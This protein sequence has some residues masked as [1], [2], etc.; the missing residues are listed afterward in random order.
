MKAQDLAKSLCYVLGQGTLL[1]QCHSSNSRLG[2]HF[3]SRILITGSVESS[4]SSSSCGWLLFQN[5]S[6][7]LSNSFFVISTSCEQIP[8]NYRLQWKLFLV[9]LSK[10][11]YTQRAFLHQRVPKNCHKNLAKSWG[12]GGGCVMV[13]LQCTS[14]PYKGWSNTPS[15]L[16]QCQYLS[17]CS[18]TP[19]LI[20]H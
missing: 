11:L 10:A 13:N 3:G 9:F 2:N 5:D 12:K 7:F 1:S 14:I 6:I 19:P 20:Q 8:H 18:P 4:I 17:N 16:D 15:S